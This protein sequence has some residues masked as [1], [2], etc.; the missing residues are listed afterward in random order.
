LPLASPRRSRRLRR[1]V[2]AA[3][4]RGLSQRH[5][6][7]ASSAIAR[8]SLSARSDSLMAPARDTPLRTTQARARR[9]ARVATARGGEARVRR[10]IDTAQNALSA[11]CWAAAQPYRIGDR[12]LR[13]DGFS[14]RFVRCKR[15]RCAVTHG[16]R[17]GASRNRLGARP[18]VRPLI[19][20]PLRRRRSA[21][22]D[23]RM[24]DSAARRC[25]RVAGSEPTPRSGRKRVPC[26]VGA[27]ASFLA[28]HKPA[29]PRARHSEC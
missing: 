23:L 21:R 18:L 12:G 25:E 5:G 10:S 1:D 14:G 27:R 24:P 29:P 15:D 19:R 3:A 26:S 20:V 2:V 16:P 9:N 17:S 22:T 28:K 7:N 11:T 8:R 4:R 13:G 6:R